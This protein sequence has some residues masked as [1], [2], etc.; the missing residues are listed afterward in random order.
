MWQYWIDFRGDEGLQVAGDMPRFWQAMGYDTDERLE[1]WRR[2]PRADVAT[3]RLTYAPLWLHCARCRGWRSLGAEAAGTFGQGKTSPRWTCEQHPVAH[4]RACLAQPGAELAALHRQHGQLDPAAAQRLAELHAQVEMKRGAPVPP[5]GRST[6]AA[7]GSNGQRRSGNAGS[8]GAGGA[9]V[10]PRRGLVAS[11]DP[12][13]TAARRNAA[14][15][16]ATAPVSLL[17][18]HIAI[19][20]GLSRDEALRRNLKRCVSHLLPETHAFWRTHDLATATPEELQAIT[21]DDIVKEHRDTTC[22]VV[23]ALEEEVEVRAGGRAAR[24]QSFARNTTA[25]ECHALTVQ[26]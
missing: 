16:G 8:N 26:E 23:S 25:N 3:Q 7:N 13:L 20:P 11:T 12:R 17:S 2:A 15:G 18:D 1:A 19:H 22:Q 10:D 4:K 21:A 24:K 9:A 5:A 14:T 6:G